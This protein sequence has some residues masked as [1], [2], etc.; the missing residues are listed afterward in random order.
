MKP[1]RHHSALGL[2][3][4]PACGPG[5]PG[6]TAHPRLEPSS[7]GPEAGTPGRHLLLPGPAATLPAPR[8]CHRAGH[9]LPAC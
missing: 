4:R 2:H 8:T 5:S 9:S 7:L 1:R 6:P 3:A